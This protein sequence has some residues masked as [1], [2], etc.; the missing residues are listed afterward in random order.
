M[1][2]IKSLFSRKKRDATQV[3]SGMTAE[4]WD[5]QIKSNREKR[6]ESLRH[7]AL[8]GESYGE[9]RSAMAEYTVEVLNTRPISELDIVK[10]FDDD[11]VTA[12]LVIHKGMALYE[13]KAIIDRVKGQDALYTIVLRTNDFDKGI[14]AIDKMTNPALLSELVAKSD[15]MMER[16]IPY[17]RR[18]LH[19]LEIEKR[20][21]AYAVVNGHSDHSITARVKKG[22]LRVGDQLQLYR[23]AEDQ[24][25]AEVADLRRMTDSW[26]QSDVNTVSKGNNAYI[27][28]DQLQDFIK[29]L[30]FNDILFVE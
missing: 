5:K 28:K 19:E 2:W 30:D 29:P 11:V 15:V 16:I 3:A 6:L 10:V 21:R 13:F 7:T 1:G 24:P 14:Y 25:S 23:A 4:K 26:R 18:R 9:R 8:K 17:L 27:P 12:D 22:E 20:V